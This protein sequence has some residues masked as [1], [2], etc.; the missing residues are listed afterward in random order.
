LNSLSKDG[1]SD[2]ELSLDLG[3]GL[4]DFCRVGSI[5]D[6]TGVG[7]CYLIGSFSILLFGGFW[8]RASGELSSRE[9]FFESNDKLLLT[10]DEAR[11][12]LD[13][14]AAVNSGFFSLFFIR[15]D[16]VALLT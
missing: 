5:F 6:V 14:G 16:N 13:T 2:T 1:F 11:K 8:R 12:D 9:L 7:G 15:A 4:K 3:L 10:L